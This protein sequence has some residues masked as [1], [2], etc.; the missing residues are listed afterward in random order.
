[1]PQLVIMLVIE[2]QVFRKHRNKR[3]RNHLFCYFAFH[4]ALY[5]FSI[6]QSSRAIGQLFQVVQSWEIPIKETVLLPYPSAATTTLF[7]CP[8]SISFCNC[9]HVWRKSL[10]CRGAESK[11][12]YPNEPFRSY[13]LG[14]WLSPFDMV[15]WNERVWER[16]QPAVDWTYLFLLT[17]NMM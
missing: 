1:M 14:M 15:C 10:D 16:T 7:F 9:M 13:S 12:N 4:R 5:P 2:T 17:D 11:L 8:K 6:T 3:D